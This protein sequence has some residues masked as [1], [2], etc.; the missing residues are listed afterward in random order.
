MRFLPDKKK[1]VMLM[2]TLLFIVSFSGLATG[3]ETT[4]NNINNDGL[5]SPLESTHTVLGEYGTASWCSHC[6]GVCTKLDNIYQS[7][8]YDFIYVS[9]VDDLNSA[10][11]NRCNELGVSGYPDTFF[12][13]NYEVSGNVD[14]SQFE[15]AIQNA[16]DDSVADVDIILTATWGG[17]GNIGVDIEVFNNEASTYNGH[18][19]VYITEIESR[20]D[21]AYGAPYDFGLLDYAINEDFSVGSG[22]PWTKTTTWDGSSWMPLEQSNIMLIAAVYDQST[23]YVDES[24]SSTPLNPNEPALSYSPSSHDFELVAEGQTYQTT[25]DIWNA[26]IDTLYWSL[27][28]SESWISYTPSSGDSA[29]EHDTVTVTIDTTGFDDGTYSGD[30]S[31]TSNGGNGSFIIEFTIL[32]LEEKTFYGYNSYDDL[33]DEGPISFPST[34]PSDI[35][36]LGPA[37]STSFLTGG[38]FVEDTWYVCEYTDGTSSY[39]DDK[40][41]TIDTTDGSYTEIGDYGLSESLNG[42]AY[43]DSTGTLYGCTGTKLYTVDPIDGSATLI[44]SMGNSGLMVGIACDGEG[45]LYGIDL[46]DESLYAID[47]ITGSATVIGDTGLSLNYAQDMAYDKDDDILFLAA[48]QESTGGELYTCDVTDGSTILV[49]A[50]GVQEVT[51]F[52][53]PYNID[54]PPI[55]HFMW[56][57]NDGSS[58][59]GTVLIFDA[60]TSTDDS[61]ITLYQWDWDNDGTYDYND[62]QPMMGHDYGDNESHA[63]TLRVTDNANQSDTYTTIVQANIIVD[64]NQENNDRGF[65]IRHALDGNWGAAQNFTPTIG[66]LLKVEMHLRSFGDPEFDLTVELRE[67]HPEG[68]LLDTVT[69]TPGEVPTSWMWFEVDFEDQIVDIG[70]N[71]FIVVPPAPSGVTTSFGYEWGYAFGDQYPDGSFWFTRDGG[72]LWRDLPTMYEFTFRTYGA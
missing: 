60:S 34:N 51:A 64:V 25:F 38:C 11:Q 61:G 6:P 32:N 2:A 40:I 4:T 20:Y 36:L 21:N 22:E 69:F 71:L 8:E 3:L 15:Y 43:D 56:E 29:G 33:M 45:S 7:G 44:G 37:G 35:T 5:R 17:A 42:L 46:G 26:G 10:A 65:P 52:A 23:G 24:V 62:T 57:D 54:S 53:I 47:P 66:S 67:D 63:V 12:D 58:N 19:H 1:K 16:E 68:T 49:G 27:S 31:I 13:A 70:S 41:W 48:Y 14:Q 28:D 50:F 59:P 9:L 30:I 18:C 72:G 39:P 55:A